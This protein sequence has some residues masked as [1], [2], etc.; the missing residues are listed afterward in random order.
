MTTKMQQSNY[1]SKIRQFKTK[2]I[3]TD[4]KWVGLIIGKG[5]ETIKRLA[6]S[7]G[8][9]CR[10]IHDRSNPGK[11]DI[12]ARTSQELL[13]AEI[14]IQKLIKSKQEDSEPKRQRN[15][16]QTTVGLSRNT[17]IYGNISNRFSSL[18]KEPETTFTPVNEL[19]GCR[20]LSKSPEEDLFRVSSKEVTRKNKNKKESK[21]INIQFRDEG[22]IRNRK[23]QKWLQHHATEED[24]HKYEDKKKRYQKTVERPQL[25]F[26]E[27]NSTPSKTVD[28]GVWGK[29]KMEKVKASKSDTPPPS[30]RPFGNLQEVVKGE[31]KEEEVFKVVM[32]TVPRKMIPRRKGNYEDDDALEKDFNPNEEMFPEEDEEEWSEGE[33]EYGRF[34]DEVDHTLLSSA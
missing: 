28:T 7:S 15:R 25:Y 8:D 12:S 3:H 27:L 34:E 5:G 10:I 26:P 21:V 22:S 32:P 13:R 23:H 29:D 19:D 30:P 14:N 17:P 6:K 11:F 16:K 20:L 24:K 18:D 31:K 1:N 33:F 2:T 4:P 9:S